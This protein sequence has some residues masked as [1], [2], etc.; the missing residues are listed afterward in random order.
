MLKTYGLLLFSLLTGGCLHP[1]GYGPTASVER[2]YTVKPGDTLQK[3]GLNLGHSPE[4]LASVNKL[5][6]PNFL[7]VGDRL[8]IPGTSSTQIMQ[9]RT[10]PVKS[11]RR[12]LW[13]VVGSISS[14]YGV[15]KGRPHR[16]VDIRAPR[17]R[18][19][20]AAHDGVVT[21]NGWQRG[22]GRVVIL[23]QGSLKTLYAHLSKSF[24]KKGQSLKR[25]EVLGH[26]GATGNA[27][28][29]HLHFELHLKGKPVDPLRF[30]NPPTQLSSL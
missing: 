28:G 15:R 7:Q 21:F 13:P 18:I 3:I 19:V 5:K 8:R 9:A 4:T 20:R 26:I 14:K 24:P 30:Y 17:G 23:K 1:P 22:Y 27:R 10:N 11:Q 16:G 6:N 29:N 12:L 25:G 2:L